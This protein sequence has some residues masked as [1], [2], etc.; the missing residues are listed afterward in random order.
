MNA[1]ELTHQKL[2]DAVHAC[3]REAIEQFKKDRDAE[4]AR[5]VE[6][7]EEAADVALAA[8]QVQCT[9][10]GHIFRESRKSRHRE[11]LICHFEEPRPRVPSEATNT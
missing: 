9:G 6:E 1:G 10:L 2:A 7:K 4:T 8:L 5:L 3:S 11:C